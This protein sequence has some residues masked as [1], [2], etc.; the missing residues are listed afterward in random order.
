MDWQ[1]IMTAV[2]GSILGALITAHLGLRNAKLDKW[3][4][5]KAE[6]YDRIISALEQLHA[7]A[8]SALEREALGRK[9][10]T[11]DDVEQEKWR[12]AERELKKALHT[13][14]YL[15]SFDVLPELN[16]YLNKRRERPT[17]NYVLAIEKEIVNSGTCMANITSIARADLGLPHLANRRLPSESRWD[18]LWRRIS[19]PFRRD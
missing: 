18:Y 3:W 8:H 1:T 4:D 6:A 10:T 13:G 2:S 14:H 17:N 16:T 9:Q 11:F 15:L 7:N 5:R 19:S 12:E